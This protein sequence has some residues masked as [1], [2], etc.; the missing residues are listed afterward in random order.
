MKVIINEG[1]QTANDNNGNTYEI[2]G[3]EIVRQDTKAKV[4]YSKETSFYKAAAASGTISYSRLNEKNQ[5]V[6]L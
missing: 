4:F 6:L 3:I 5:L 1:Q 2:I